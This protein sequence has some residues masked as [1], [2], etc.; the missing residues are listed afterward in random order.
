MTAVIGCGSPG[1][2]TCVGVIDGVVHLFATFVALSLNKC[3]PKSI[4]VHIHIVYG[5]YMCTPTQ[6]INQFVTN[7]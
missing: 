4:Y 7:S 6:L 1:H 2:G 3:A 5:L